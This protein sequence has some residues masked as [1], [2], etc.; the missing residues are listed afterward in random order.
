MFLEDADVNALACGGSAAS[1][2]A[3][4]RAVWAGIDIDA[5][6][7]LLYDPTGRLVGELLI[8]VL[9]VEEVSGA[10]P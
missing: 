10:R 9:V 4:V 2:A 5:F 7:E 6:E 3:A 1:L 8:G